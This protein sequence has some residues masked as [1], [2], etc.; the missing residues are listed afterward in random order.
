MRN[1]LTRQDDL[2]GLFKT[3]AGLVEDFW[4]VLD[5]PD[6]PFVTLT[7]TTNGARNFPPYNIIESTKTGKVRLEMAV[8][9]YT[10][11]RLKV[12][13]KGNV[14]IIA[15]VPAD[16]VAD[17]KLRHKGIANASFLRTFDLKGNVI[18]E[19]VSLLDGILTVTVAA[20]NPVP[21]NVTT[22]E[23]K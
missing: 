16:A 20:K 8:A 7:S 5:H 17:D 12:E 1:A 23:I 18:I 14:L 11:D 10:R 22:F 9:G 15:G 21:E 3:G 19:D 2:Y 13:L 6:F 4:N